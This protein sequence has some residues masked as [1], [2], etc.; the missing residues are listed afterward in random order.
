[1]YYAQSDHRDR[2][3]PFVTTSRK[4]YR[5]QH[6]IVCSLLH[7]IHS[8]GVQFTPVH[9]RFLYFLSITQCTS[10]Q[11]KYRHL[12]AALNTVLLIQPSIIYQ[13]TVMIAYYDNEDS[14]RLYC[15]IC[16][17]VLPI[18]IIAFAMFIM[19]ICNYD[20]TLGVG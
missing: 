18:E 3:A 5:C 12:Q 8:R 19:C 17:E 1:M 11:N 16:S 4:V 13:C 20:F 15:G 2:R 14:N 10:L 6:Q 9:E 7:V